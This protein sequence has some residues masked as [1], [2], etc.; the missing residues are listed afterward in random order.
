MNSASE[1]DGVA[2]GCGAHHGRR[3]GPLDGEKVF[4]AVNP[5]RRGFIGD[6][7]YG[8][9][10]SEYLDRGYVPFVFDYA[11]GSELFKRAV[12]AAVARW[13]GF[14]DNGVEPIMTTREF[15]D[16]YPLGSEWAFAG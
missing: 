1:S 15:Q 12:S 3:L 8:G 2:A 7:W 6:E 5:K 14:V 10:A 9:P 11:P 4:Y 13:D 16:R